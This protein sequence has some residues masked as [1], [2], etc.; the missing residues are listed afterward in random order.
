M[1]LFSL[2]TVWEPVALGL[3]IIFVPIMLQRPSGRSKA[4]ENA[5]YLAERLQ[6]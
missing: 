5:S 3:V 4:K 2:K 1:D 6:K